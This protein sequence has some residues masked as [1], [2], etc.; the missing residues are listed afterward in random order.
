VR[1]TTKSFD[2]LDVVQIRVLFFGLLKDI[3][4]LA[5]D[6]IE[7]PA[8]STAGAVFEH[9]AAA[10][11][12][13]RQMASSIVLARNHD[14][15]TTKEPLAEGD[16]VALLPPVSGGSL[17]EIEDPDGHFFALTRAPIDL[18][19]LETRLLRGCDGASVTFQ[20]VVRN[21]TSGRRTVRLEYECYEP[22]AIRKMAEIGREIAGQCA[23][24]RIAMVHRLGTME[25]GEASV[26][27][28]VTAP[29]R[30]QAFDAALEGIN[31]LKRLVPVWK[32]EFFEDGEVW[33]E[34]DWDRNA[35]R[36]SAS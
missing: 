25:V 2:S 11:P 28:V 5:E 20:G 30:K 14:F 13:L 33:V 32:K 6:R 23:I 3:C 17:S 24:D 34:G 1:D 4:G 26:A 21:N 15:A 35:P 8:G 10:F 19:A 18:R 36:V 29:H 9:Y 16:E 31:R 7:L 12:K 22:M 27:V